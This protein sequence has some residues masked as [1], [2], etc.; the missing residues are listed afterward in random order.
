MAQMT[1]SF[2]GLTDSINHQRLNVDMNQL[3]TKIEQFLIN[4]YAEAFNN[5]IKKGLAKSVEY[6][7]QQTNMAMD[8]ASKKV[9]REIQKTAGKMQNASWNV[10][11]AVTNMQYLR[12]D[13]A[14]NQKEMLESNRTFSKLTLL[15]L[16]ISIIIGILGSFM[17]ITSCFWHVPLLYHVVSSTFGTI[18]HTGSAQSKFWCV[19]LGIVIVVLIIGMPLV[20]PLTI[21]FIGYRHNWWERIG[22][23]LNKQFDNLTIHYFR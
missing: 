18:L 13:F 16:I 11:E 5:Q 21:W 2:N 1:S 23:T 12:D 9:S 22:D 6:Y 14:N 8:N 4:G 17:M 10:K 7:I 20:I 15:S 19:V 3:S